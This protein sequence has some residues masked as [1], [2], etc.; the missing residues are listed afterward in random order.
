MGPHDLLF[1]SVFSEPVHAAGLLR[2]VIPKSLAE[3]A[4]WSTLRALSVS[5]IDSA[6]KQHT[7]D[8]L[9]SVELSGQPTLVH[10]LV[11]HQST[12]ETRMPLRIL[13]YMLAAWEQYA[14]QHPA[15]EKLP[16]IVAVVVH[17]DEQAWRRATQLSELLTCDAATLEWLGAYVPDFRFV[18]ED[19]SPG[20]ERKLHLRALTALGQV[21]LYCLMRSRFSKNLLAELRDAVWAP[22]IEVVRAPHGL[23]AFSQLLS[24]ITQTTDTPMAE[25]QDFAKQLG[26][27]AEKTAMTLAERLE[28]KGIEKG[29]AQ[30]LLRQLEV[31]F[32]TLDDA[33]RERVLSARADEVTRWGERV[34]SAASLDEVFA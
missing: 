10:L 22:L 24:Y 5:I 16:P 14:A 11:E 28:Q 27:R 26:P 21:A 32:R 12:S 18:L 8:I 6:L 1:R 34:L 2:S 17:H 15:G 9:L 23:A 20:L 30:L 33:V 29:S 13:R 31:K 3:R 7:A 4:D 25:L 19:L